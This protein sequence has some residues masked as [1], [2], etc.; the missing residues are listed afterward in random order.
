MP[1][2]GGLQEFTSP[3]ISKW[4]SKTLR[5]ILFHLVF[6]VK[7]NSRNP[8]KILRFVGENP[9]LRGENKLSLGSGLLDG[10]HHF[11][12]SILIFRSC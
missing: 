11:T 6:E 8:P 9:N 2:F 5:L 3:L 10:L 7:E 4:K 1:I 12:K